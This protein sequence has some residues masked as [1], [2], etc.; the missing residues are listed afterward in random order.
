[1]SR[2]W[3]FAIKCLNNSFVDSCTNGTRSK[4]SAC[5]LAHDA[6]DDGMDG[7]FSA[8]AVIGEVMGKAESFFAEGFGKFLLLFNFLLVKDAPKLIQSVVRITTEGRDVLRGILANVDCSRCNGRSCRAVRIAL[9]ALHTNGGEIA[10]LVY[11]RTEIYAA[12]QQVTDRDAR[13]VLHLRYRGYRSWSAIAEEMKLSLRQI[14]R[15][16]GE[17]LKKFSIRA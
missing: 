6:A 11:L 12:I 8:A 16:H 9:V 15:L 4:V 7:D 17:G 2:T 14:Y 3:I 13:R 10:S 1:M 5:D